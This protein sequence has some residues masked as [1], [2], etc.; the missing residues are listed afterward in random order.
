VKTKMD[1]SKI[2][3]LAELEIPHR[4][5]KTKILKKNRMIK[6]QNLLYLYIFT[7]TSKTRENKEKKTLP[8]IIIEI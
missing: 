2:F 3:T 8:I 4:E 1:D 5:K 6:Y 7:N